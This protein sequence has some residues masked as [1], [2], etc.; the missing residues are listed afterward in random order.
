MSIKITQA[1]THLVKLETKTGPK[2]YMYMYKI[3][4]IEYSFC[5]ILNIPLRMCTALS[6][7]NM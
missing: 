5:L 2:S 6:K 1:E 4:L 7:S 3:H